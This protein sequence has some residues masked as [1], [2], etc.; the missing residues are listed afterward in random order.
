MKWSDSINYPI[1]LYNSQPFYCHFLFSSKMAAL[2][3]LIKIWFLLIFVLYYRW[4]FSFI[5]NNI[6][7]QK[8]I[9]FLNWLKRR[10]RPIYPKYIACYNI[11]CYSTGTGHRSVK[12][13]DTFNM[14][15]IKFNSFPSMFLFVTTI[16]N[17]VTRTEIFCFV[18]I[19]NTYLFYEIYMFVMLHLNLWYAS[20]AG[21]WL[22]N[23]MLNI[24]FSLILWS[25]DFSDFT[26]LFAYIH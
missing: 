9:F 10:Y 7:I 26:M 12:Y 11:K 21:L 4:H 19:S 22:T 20:F 14:Y 16:F 2:I 3:L 24:G 1:R 8:Y 25:I 17:G 18:Q 6:K 23:Q 5:T 13:S 15:N